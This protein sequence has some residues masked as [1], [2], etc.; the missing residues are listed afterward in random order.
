MQGYFWLPVYGKITCIIRTPNLQHCHSLC[1]N[2]HFPD[3]SGLAGTR[4]SPFWILLEL[5]MVVTTGAIRHAKLQWKHHCHI[6]HRQMFQAQYKQPSQQQWQPQTIYIYT[7]TSKCTGTDWTV[8]A[9][10]TC[11]NCCCW[12]TDASGLMF[13]LIHCCWAAV[14]PVTS[15][16]MLDMSTRPITELPP[17]HRRWDEDCWWPTHSWLSALLGLDMD[18]TVCSVWQQIGAP[19]HGWGGGGC[20]IPCPTACRTT[21]IQFIVRSSTGTYL[22]HFS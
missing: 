16:H 20:H 19:K 18:R 10:T 13:L 14:T 4:T 1:L 9:C 8:T 6:H 7:D 12:N 11:I 3:G 17:S 21:T 5:R 22:L 2:G 15:D